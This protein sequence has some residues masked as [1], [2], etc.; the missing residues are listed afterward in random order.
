MKDELDYLRNMYSEKQIVEMWKFCLPELKTNH[1]ETLPELKANHNET[2]L[3]WMNEW[4]DKSSKKT[5]ENSFNEKS[6]EWTIIDNI[7]KFK[8]LEIKTTDLTDSQMTIILTFD[9]FKRH[10][11]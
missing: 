2:V 3:N 11:E 5:F 4:L 7:G 10:D 9:E 8:G 1:D 6:D